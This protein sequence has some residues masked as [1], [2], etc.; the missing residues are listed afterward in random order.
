MLAQIVAVVSAWGAPAEA[1]EGATVRSWGRS[2]D[3]LVGGVCGWL[4]LGSQQA[5]VWKAEPCAVG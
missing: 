5:Q 1:E 2:K 4:W 3:L